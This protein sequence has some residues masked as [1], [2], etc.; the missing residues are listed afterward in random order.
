MPDREEV[1]SGLYGAYRLAYFDAS[2]MAHFFLHYRDGL[3]RDAL[4]AHL[5]QVYSPNA[6]TRD[7]AQGLDVLTGVSF[8]ELDRQY[9]DY[10]AAQREALGERPAANVGAQ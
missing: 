2:G 1:L 4:I 8:G 10:L 6:R 3:Y 7:R 5:S 9:Q